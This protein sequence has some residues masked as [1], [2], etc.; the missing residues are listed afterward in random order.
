MRFYGELNVQIKCPNMK[1][2]TFRL[3]HRTRI[4]QLLKNVTSP[5]EIIPD[6]AWRHFQETRKQTWRQKCAIFFCQLVSE[7]RSILPCY[8]NNELHV[9]FNFPIQYLLWMKIKEIKCFTCFCVVVFRVLCAYSILFTEK[10]ALTV[11]FF[12]KP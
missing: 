3:I 4:M 11:G 9:P 10:P 12:K 8:I 5:A 2:R 1:E 7:K 6:E